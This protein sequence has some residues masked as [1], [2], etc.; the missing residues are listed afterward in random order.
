MVDADGIYAVLL[1]FLL[2]ALAL[3]C[4]VVVGVR[5]W[6]EAHEQFLRQHW[7]QHRPGSIPKTHRP[8]ASKS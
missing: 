4:L 2:L 6:Q 7:R 5:L 1:A 3:L 8:G